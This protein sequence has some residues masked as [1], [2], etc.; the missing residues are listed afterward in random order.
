[1]AG[2]NRCKPKG[3]DAMPWQLHG[4]LQ[5]AAAGTEFLAADS[6]CNAP[7][8]AVGW[9]VSCC[10]A[11]EQCMSTVL[12]DAGEVPWSEEVW[13]ALVGLV[14]V[15]VVLFVLNTLHLQVIT[16]STATL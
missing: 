8:N 12:I 15:G 13:H 2:E 16:A 11:P 6:W 10:H 5:G 14:D 1:M 7:S 9:L 4:M 3:P